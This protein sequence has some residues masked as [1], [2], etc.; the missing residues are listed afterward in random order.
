MDF[1]QARVGGKERFMGDN[2]EMLAFQIVQRF[3][4]SGKASS[5]RQLQVE[6]PDVQPP[7]RR[8][9]GVKLAQGACGCV[10]G[11]GH[12][13]LPLYFPAA[14]DFLKHGAGHINLS[15][16]NEPGQLLRQRHGN[17]ADGAQVL[18]HVLP[19]PAVA[20]CPTADKYAIPIL[21]RH[22]QSVYL[23]LQ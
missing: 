15:S 17:G 22:R 13:G 12:E 19:H 16:D 14:V 8:D 5:L 21:Q 23:R 3:G 9:F 11:V 10:S 1:L 18:R 4:V 6:N 7:F 20:S 2:G